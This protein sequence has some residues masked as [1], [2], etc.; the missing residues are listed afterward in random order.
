MISSDFRKMWFQ[1]FKPGK[2]LQARQG[3]SGSVFNVK[4]I[5]GN[6]SFLLIIYITL[7]DLLEVYGPE[8]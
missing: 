3:K 7:W 4:N 6:E 5:Q 8:K 2:H 1:M